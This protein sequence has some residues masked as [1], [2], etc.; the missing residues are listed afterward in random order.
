MGRTD[1]GIYVVKVLCV[2]LSSKLLFYRVSLIMRKLI[3][4]VLMN[5]VGVIRIRLNEEV[6]KLVKVTIG[7]SNDKL[8]TYRGFECVKKIKW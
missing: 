2:E 4:I 8:I 3:L 6:T 7:S 1:I 5:N